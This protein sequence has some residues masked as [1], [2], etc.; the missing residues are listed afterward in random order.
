MLLF[1]K[2]AAGQAYEDIKIIKQFWNLYKPF[3]RI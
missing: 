1:F 2:T 3:G